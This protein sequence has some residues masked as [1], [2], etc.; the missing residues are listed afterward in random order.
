MITLQSLGNSR[1]PLQEAQTNPGKSSKYSIVFEFWF[2][3]D[4]GVILTEFSSI[5]FIFKCH[6]ITVRSRFK[7]NRILG[8]FQGFV[9]DSNRIRMKLSWNK[10]VIIPAY[11]RISSKSG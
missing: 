7:H 10:I 9:W 6:P 5:I 11:K 1:V 4:Q 3:A 8:N 2:N